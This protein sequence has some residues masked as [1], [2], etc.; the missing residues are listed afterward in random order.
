MGTTQPGL[1]HPPIEGSARCHSAMFG[2]AISVARFG[3]VGRE[4]DRAVRRGGIDHC[5]ARSA[6]VEREQSLRGS[7]LVS[8]DPALGAAPGALPAE[9]AEQRIVHGRPSL[10]R[11]RDFESHA[12]QAS[13][14]ARRR[15]PSHRQPVVVRLL[16]QQAVIAYDTAPGQ[17]WRLA[18][19]PP[20][21]ERLSE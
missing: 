9:V 7:D 4:H 2:V 15:S 13:N 5:G 20:D 1:I 16:R 3:P 14:R 19:P 17:F 12:A 10:E 6:A 11:E 21:W 8:I 18:P